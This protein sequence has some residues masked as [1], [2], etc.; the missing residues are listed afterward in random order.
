MALSVLTH[1]ASHRSLSA[2]AS[3]SQ[4]SKMSR[5]MDRVPTGE[6]PRANASEEGLHLTRLAARGEPRRQSERR[7]APKRL[8]K[9]GRTRQDT[10]EGEDCRLPREVPTATRKVAIINSFR[11]LLALSRQSTLITIIF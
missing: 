2:Q 9:R 10:A 1:H 5:R 7:Q 8:G 3:H 4:T 11:T 6:M